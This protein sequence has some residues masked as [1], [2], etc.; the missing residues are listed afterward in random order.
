MHCWR[1]AQATTEVSSGLSA[2]EAA[3]IG[4]GI[5]A[6]AALL[7]AI[8]TAWLN[9]RLEA[10]R[11]RKREIAA[12]R[13]ARVEQITAQ[14]S[15]LYGPLRLLTAQSAVLAKKLRE[16]KPDPESW[17]LLGHLSEVVDDSK[18]LA[19][20]E[21]IMQINGDIEKRVLSEAGLL[22]TGQVPESL[23]SFLGHYRQLEVA[24]ELAKEGKAAQEIVAEFETYPREFDKYVNEAYDELQ[25]ERENL[26]REPS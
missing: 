12:S 26:E 4:A 7:A 6:L 3:L 9:Y 25:A 14:L 22:R 20:V 23:V 5:A 18:D 19:L 8:L 24:F 15:G 21:Q 2:G 16:G 11:D 13:V 10:R 1:A 17:S